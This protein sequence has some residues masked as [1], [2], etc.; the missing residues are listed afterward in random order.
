MMWKSIKIHDKLSLEFDIPMGNAAAIVSIRDLFVE[1]IPLLTK[2][3][4]PIQNLKNDL[5]MSDYDRDDVEK[6]TKKNSDKLMEMYGWRRVMWLA[7]A[8]EIL[9]TLDGRVGD[10]V[11]VY[12]GAIRGKPPVNYPEDCRI[13]TMFDALW[14]DQ[15]L[16][17]R[18][19]IIDH[20][21]RENK[22]IAE[23]YL[24]NMK[25]PPIE[26]FHEDER[27]GLTYSALFRAYTK[28][29]ESRRK[30]KAEA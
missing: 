18:D 26:T 20:W 27:I 14:R 3:R 7:E 28:K 9:V 5:F 17:I 12:Y 11:Y 19:G 16:I 15:R 22:K 8:Q 24:R 23:Q 21:L 30:A 29:L 25:I 2:E 10:R 6:Y 1:G 4:F 13:A